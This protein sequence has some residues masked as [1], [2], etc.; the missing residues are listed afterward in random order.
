MFY[1]LL[2]DF[3]QRIIAGT[4]D[5]DEIQF[6]ISTNEEG[7][8]PLVNPPSITT[9]YCEFSSTYYVQIA[10]QKTPIL[11]WISTSSGLNNLN[12]GQF[13][14]ISRRRE[15]RLLCDVNGRQKL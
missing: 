15:L 8:W 6:I 9:Y 10:L 3:C 2:E 14:V 11:A 7:P 12:S 1:G 5:A 4:M 13:Y